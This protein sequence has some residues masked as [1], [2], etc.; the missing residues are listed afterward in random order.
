MPQV[1]HPA[2]GCLQLNFGTLEV[3]EG[4]VRLFALDPVVDIVLLPKTHLLFLGDGYAL[5]MPDRANERVMGLLEQHGIPF[6]A[7]TSMC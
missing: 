5:R 3:V 1:L 2:A 4:A 6:T 7:G